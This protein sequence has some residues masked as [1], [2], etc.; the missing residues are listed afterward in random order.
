MPPKRNPNKN[1]EKLEKQRK[2]IEEERKKRKKNMDKLIE[3]MAAAQER[4]ERNLR[5][6]KKMELQ[7]EMDKNKEENKKFNDLKIASKIAEALNKKDKDDDDFSAD[8]I[9]LLQELEPAPQEEEEEEGIS[10]GKLQSALR[11]N[12]VE[13]RKK[14]K[15]LLMKGKLKI[16]GDNPPSDLNFDGKLRRHGKGG[17]RTRKKRGGDKYFDKHKKIIKDFL[18]DPEVAKKIK[19]YKKN[20][21]S[22]NQIMKKI[23]R[24]KLNKIIKAYARYLKSQKGGKDPKELERL[25]NIEINRPTPPIGTVP[26]TEL[27]QQPQGEE[28]EINFFEILDGV[29]ALTQAQ[30]Q[31][32]RENR[33]QQRREARFNMVHSLVF[34]MFM[35]L[36]VFGL[37]VDGTNA[38][39]ENI[40]AMNVLGQG[41]IMAHQTGLLGTAQNIIIWDAYWRFFN[42]AWIPGGFTGEDLIVQRQLARFIAPFFPLP[43]LRDDQEI[44][45]PWEGGGS[46]PNSPQQEFADRIS[47]PVDPFVA[48]M[49]HYTDQHNSFIRVI[50]E[51]IW[52][53]Q[54][55]KLFQK[56]KKASGT[57][58][59]TVV[60]QLMKKE[61]AKAH[62]TLIQNFDRLVEDYKNTVHQ[63]SPPKKFSFEQNTLIECFDTAEN[64]N[65]IGNLTENLNQHHY[66]FF[67][68]VLKFLQ[69]VVGKIRSDSKLNTPSGNY[70]IDPIDCFA[71]LAIIVSYYRV[72]RVSRRMQVTQVFNDLCNT[73]LLIH[74]PDLMNKSFKGWQR[75]GRKK[76]RKRRKKG[77]NRKKT[78]K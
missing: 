32:A 67:L 19:K 10:I 38:D 49:Q 68:Y 20:K 69:I 33:N 21:L 40:P 13:K 17:R 28:E 75:G 15:D 30:R 8:A 53:N 25:N 29:I 37:L 7:I 48:L 72:Y 39:L 16:W 2:K 23:T 63:D 45:M 70:E 9:R 78:R 34:S 43:E 26:R 3:Q 50:F 11:K 62:S 12:K 41:I 31:Q 60:I 54:N 4:A 42:N 56:I 24:D 46:R 73:I 64:S 36:T 14:N 52:A 74:K 35:L 44:P 76:T 18:E 66:L 51:D 71:L 61:F 57:M 47:P 59:D 1:K 5:R 77:K 6:F 55:R 65:Y 22:I 27:G 58:D